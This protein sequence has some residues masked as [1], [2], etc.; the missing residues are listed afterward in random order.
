VTTWSPA[1]IELITKYGLCEECGQPMG[2]FYSYDDDALEYTADS[3]SLQCT[4]DPTHQREDVRLKW[5]PRHE[6]RP[7][8][9]DPTHGRI[10][11]DIQWHVDDMKPF[12]IGQ[13]VAMEQTLQD[14]RDGKTWPKLT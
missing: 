13:R 14:R 8:L 5:Y 3:S 10:D 4:A 7:T 2:V 6:R 1:E 12:S 11:R 9:G